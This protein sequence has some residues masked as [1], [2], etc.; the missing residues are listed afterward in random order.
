[1]YLPAHCPFRM[2]DIWR[3]LIAQRIAWANGWCILF[4]SADVWQDRNEHNLMAD[5]A[6]EVSGYLN[7]RELAE[8]L[9]ALR[10]EP[11]LD[12]IADSMRRCYGVLLEMNLIGG[13][14]LTLLEAWQ[15]DIDRLLARD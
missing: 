7:N 4:H 10:I 3:S 5:L 1:M 13:E 11:G 9:S 8:R 14:E 12:R 6:D 2:T 15:R